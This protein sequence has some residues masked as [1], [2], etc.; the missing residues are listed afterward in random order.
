MPTDKTIYNL[1]IIKCTINE[2]ISH[3]CKECSSDLPKRLIKGQTRG[4]VA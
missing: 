3:I 2:N 4:K 1:I